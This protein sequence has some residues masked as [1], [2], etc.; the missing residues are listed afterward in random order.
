MV[1]QLA[2]VTITGRLNI[3]DAAATKINA[4]RSQIGV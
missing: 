1:G 2:L 3:P 4:E